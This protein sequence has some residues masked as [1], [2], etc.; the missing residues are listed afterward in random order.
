MVWTGDDGQLGLWLDVVVWFSHASSLLGIG[1]LR[2]SGAND[3]LQR[4]TRSLNR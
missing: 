1:R 3:S 2:P 4:L